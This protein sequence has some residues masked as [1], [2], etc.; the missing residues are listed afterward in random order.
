MVNSDL[1]V[2]KREEDVFQ[3]Y[4]FAYR[5]ASVI[6][7]HDK[8]DSIVIGV[9]GKW[10]EGKTSVLNFIKEELKLDPNIVV[11]NFNP[12]LFRDEDQLLKSFFSVLAKGINVSIESKKEKLGKRLL[13]YAD[14]IGAAGSLVGL[15]GAKGLLQYFGKKY[16]NIFIEGYKEKVN[17]GLEESGKRV[18]VVM[19]DIDRLS[20]SE[21]QAIF[22]IVKLVAD[23]K[24]TVYLLSFDDELV[25]SALDSHYSKGGYDYLEKIIQLPLTLPKAQLSVVRNYTLTYV[26]KVF[27]T[28]KIKLDESEKE[29][30][31]SAL[32]QFLLSFITTPRVAVRYAN[33]ISFTLPMVRGE[34]NVVD[35]ILIEGL[36][37]IFPK[38]YNFIKNNSSFFLKTYN[39]YSFSGGKEVQT[40]EEAK[41]YIEDQLKFYSI[42]SSRKIEGLL[43]IIFPQLKIVFENDS[44]SEHESKDWFADKRI[45]SAKYFERYFTYAIIEGEIS[46]VVFDEIL[47]QITKV[48]FIDK[49][50]E[51]IQLFSD[52]NMD[53]V[54]LKIQYL[55]D[56]FTPIQ[57]RFLAL[58][59][60]LIAEV[61]PVKDSSGS[62]IMSP[63]KQLAYFI[64]K[65]VADQESKNRVELGV[66][67]V[68]RAIPLN[69][70][71]EIWRTLHPKSDGGSRPDVLSESD[72][73]EI[74]KTLYL[75][76]RSELSLDQLYDSMEDSSFRYLLEIGSDENQEE[77]KQEIKDWVETN[78]GNF[79]KLLYAFSQTTHSFSGGKAGNKTYKSSFSQAF[80][81][82]LKKVVDIDFLYSL[83]IELYGDQSDFEPTSDR[84]ALTDEQLVGWF[85]LEHLKK[86]TKK[87]NS[88]DIPLES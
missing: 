73:Q 72:F 67:L 68:N 59:L 66:K 81:D 54:S 80:Y 43:K 47:D 83:S 49:S 5:I 11:V 84:D 50:E 63:F 42:T 32:D 21:V 9:Y 22:R 36:K 4:P 60:C 86:E 58:N 75:R 70:A 55:E 52:F 33:S 24:N 13:D 20:N 40:K 78:K 39:S 61:F 6:K 56:S 65:C 62:T 14:A 44:Y 19:D 71:F 38:L 12:W 79:I 7:K 87:L 25:A 23:F 37:V 45:C 30:F 35:L 64:Q 82:L 3:R 17:Q 53:E 1:P 76:C 27:Q 16:S 31:T 28:Q 29:R 51:L 69:F 88:D 34:V 74:S 57:K 18:V 41:I 85:Q 26:L 15:S 2:S 8:T 77:I 46:D 48:D 10:G